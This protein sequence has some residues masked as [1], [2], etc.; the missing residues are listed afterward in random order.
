MKNL[1]VPYELAV[2]AFEKG[3]NEIECLACYNQNKELFISIAG[4]GKKVVSNFALNNDCSNHLAAP[5]Y[6]QIV[7]WFREKHLIEISVFSVRE[8]CYGWNFEFMSL[9]TG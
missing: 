3:A 1:F 7:D 2:L 4:I 6:Q 5:L 8:Y 9:W